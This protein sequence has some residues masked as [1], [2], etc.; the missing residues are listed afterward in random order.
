MIIQTL[1]VVMKSIITTIEEELWGEYTTEAL[2]IE[3]LGS[4]VGEVEGECVS[5]VVA[6][7][8]QVVAVVV[9]V[10]AVVVQVVAVVVQVVAVVVQVAEEDHAESQKVF[11]W[12]TIGKEF[13]NSQILSGRKGSS[14]FLKMF[15]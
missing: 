7:V 4:I 2:G 3:D 6:V 10:V 8:V 9:Q 11:E 15:L 14:E 5:Q 1:T 13:Q 12:I